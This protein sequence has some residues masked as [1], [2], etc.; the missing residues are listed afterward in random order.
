MRESIKNAI[1]SILEKR[2][3]KLG[4]SEDLVEKLK[5]NLRAE[6]KYWF[7]S[8]E[9]AWRRELSGALGFADSLLDGVA[10]GFED[11]YGLVVDLRFR[12][13]EKGLAGSSSGVMAVL[14]EVGL[15]FDRLLGLPYYPG[16]TLKGAVRDSAE[17]ILK[18]EPVNLLFGEKDGV[19]ALVFSDSYPVGCW[20]GRCLVVTGDVVTPHYFVPGRGLVEA[21][22]EAK[23]TPVFHL[24]VA[25]GT[26]F[27]VVVGVDLG[28]LSDEGVNKI[29]SDARDKGLITANEANQQD[30]TGILGLAVARLIAAAFAGGVAARS[31]KGYNILLPVDPGEVERNVI[32]GFKFRTRG[33]KGGRGRRR[34]R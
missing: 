5:D 33:E 16:S 25:P 24:A 18:P 11:L 32:V 7:L 19:G 4:S 30:K 22:Y 9:S 27:R 10:G 23:P 29:I 3:D 6:V 17:S 13:A 2:E 1:D 21:E 8:S 14:L 26:V 31:G 12:L 28:R 20:K 34:Y 15:A